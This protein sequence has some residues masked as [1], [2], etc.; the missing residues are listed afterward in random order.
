[1][2]KVKDRTSSEAPNVSRGLSGASGPHILPGVPLGREDELLTP[3]YWKWRCS[4]G[5]EE[6][7]DYF[8]QGGALEDEVIF[9]Q[10]RRLV[11]SAIFCR[12][13]V[14]TVAGVYSRDYYLGSL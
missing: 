14:K 8:A 4:I 9:C 12:S 6:G 7:H 1:M 5:E 11:H 3:A 10:V 13:R 2:G